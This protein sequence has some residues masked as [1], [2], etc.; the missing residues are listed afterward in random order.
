MPKFGVES[1]LN[2]AQGLLNR[3]PRHTLLKYPWSRKCPSAT[4]QTSVACLWKAIVSISTTQHA[5][6][7]L[8]YPFEAQQKGD[9]GRR[10]APGRSHPTTNF[11]LS[12]LG[13]GGGGKI[14]ETQGEP[15]AWVFYSWKQRP[16]VWCSPLF[17]IWLAELS[18]SLPLEKKYCSDFDTRYY[19]WNKQC[20]FHDRVD[21]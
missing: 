19:Q 8:I 5:H 17:S 21:V 18:V 9:V 20:H 14:R 7:L 3:A 12:S 6:W 13:L 2:A 10:K 16:A 1:L 11:K 4:F 15:I